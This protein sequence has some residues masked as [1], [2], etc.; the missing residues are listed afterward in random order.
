MGHASNGVHYLGYKLCYRFDLW[1]SAQLQGVH[2]H[3]VPHW[4]TQRISYLQPAILIDQLDILVNA[5][6]DAALH[7]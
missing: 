3:V 4:N 5:R 2:V 1:V 7:E 6:F